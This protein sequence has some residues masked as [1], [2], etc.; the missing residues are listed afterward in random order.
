MGLPTE[1]ARARAADAIDR[2]DWPEVL[3]ALRAVDTNALTGA[4]LYA[5]AEAEGAAASSPDAVLASLEL[6]HAAYVRED[7]M[8]GAS[9]TALR[10]V[11]LAG[12]NNEPEVSAAWLATLGRTMNDLPECRVHVLA[13]VLASYRTLAEGQIEATL[14]LAQQAQKL[15]RQLGDRELEIWARQREAYA[16]VRSGDFDRGLEMLDESMVGAISLDLMPSVRGALLCH[17]ITLC[18]EVGDLKRAIS[19]L[20]AG[21][22]VTSACGINFSGE[23]HMHRADVLKT[24]GS[25][26]RAEAEARLGCE[27]Y[28]L[29]NPHLGWGWMQLGEIRLRA[30]DLEGAEDAFTVAYS[31]NYLPDPGLAMLRMARGQVDLAVKE[32]DRALVSLG[33]PEYAYALRVDET[34]RIRLLA[35]AVTIRVA[36]GDLDAATAACD[37]LSEA[38]EMYHSAAFRAAASCAQGELHLARGDHGEAEKLLRDAISQWIQVGAPYEGAVARV[39]LGAALAA[40]GEPDQARLELKAAARVFEELGAE[41]QRQRVATMLTDLGAGGEVPPVEPRVDK[42]FMFTD[43]ESSTALATAMGEDE[44]DRV[45]RWHDRL[46]GD[47]ISEHGGVVVKHE[48]DGVFAAFGDGAGAVEAAVAIQKRLAA[49][50]EQHGFAPAVRIGVHAGSAIERGGDFFGMAVNTAARV[51]TLASGGQIVVSESLSAECGERAR[52]PRSIELKG[53]GAPTTVIDVNWQH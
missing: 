36:A 28:G 49:H 26:A 17:G 20:H 11:F 15:A 30:G 38:V 34:A 46:I 9:W 2:R 10:L 37:E 24:Q 45:L 44:W 13:S 29:E 40:L 53:L 23:C 50:R 21:D 4:E 1:E 6:A 48:G 47:C 8:E 18:Q 33:S 42:A 52:D 31:K 3:R 32:I 43:I 41:H 19:W 39:H 25:L 35:A 51:M 5:L 7:D 27:G 14:D 22:R 16:T 12:A